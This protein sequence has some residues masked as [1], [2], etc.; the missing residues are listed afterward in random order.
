MGFSQYLTWCFTNSCS[1]DICQIS[2]VG[3]YTSWYDKIYSWKFKLEN[4]LGWCYQNIS[5]F[6]VCS[7]PVRCVTLHPCGPSAVLAPILTGK[8]H[9]FQS[10]LRPFT[11]HHDRISWFC[12]YCNIR[13]CQR[14]CGKST[15]LQN[16]EPL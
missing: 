14:R 9:W 7:N 3:I 2:Y 12:Y 8:S 15:I 1:I 11:S 10:S 16:Q 13:K 4:K 5:V 6:A